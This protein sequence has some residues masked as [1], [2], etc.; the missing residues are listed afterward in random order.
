M[1]D[2]AAAS[3]DGEAAAAVAGRFSQ[4]ILAASIPAQLLALLESCADEVDDLAVR[5][6]LVNLAFAIYERAYELRLGQ[7]TPEDNRPEHELVVL[8]ATLRICWRSGAERSSGRPFDESELR[9]A[10]ATALLHD[11]C[12]IP[13]ITEE[14]VVAARAADPVAARALEE[15]KATQRTEHM[16]QGAELALRL[17]RAAP[18]LLDDAESRQCAGYIALHDAWKLGW[19]C[20]LDSDWLAV[21]CLEGD[22]LWPVD[23]DFGP[24]A[25]LERKGVGRPTFAQ[26]RDQAAANLRNQLVAY[27][28]QFA[29]CGQRFSDQDTML[30]TREGARMLAELRDYWGI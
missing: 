12:F 21:C 17:L 20:P 30:R 22:A 13:R 11:L 18:R 3:E 24:L 5:A 25:D 6:R 19:P 15:R 14:M 16:R 23:R 7:R 26:L 27:R 4:G 10:V 8:R 29:A 28:S 2:R 1:E 9:V